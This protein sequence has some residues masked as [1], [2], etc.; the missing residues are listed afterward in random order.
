M[1]P[2]VALAFAAPFFN[3]PTLAVD[4]PVAPLLEC[5]RLAGIHL[6]VD[7]SSRL[8][9]SRQLV[10]LAFTDAQSDADLAKLTA[11][12]DTEFGTRKGTA[13]GFRSV[14][15]LPLRRFVRR[16]LRS[17]LPGSLRRRTGRLLPQSWPNSMSAPTTA[18]TRWVRAR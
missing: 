17:G 6:G 18:A 1:R 11:F 16:L 14:H 12:F 5:A 7:V 3:E 2:G 15:S 9:G 8:P 10:K 13:S 4:R